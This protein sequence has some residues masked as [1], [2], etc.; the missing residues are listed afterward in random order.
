MVRSQKGFTAS[1]SAT[2][3]STMVMVPPD[4]WQQR[5]SKTADKS[6]SRTPRQCSGARLRY[7]GVGSDPCSLLYSWTAWLHKSCSPRWPG[8][9]SLFPTATTVLHS[10]D[11]VAARRWYQ[12]G[13]LRR[14]LYSDRTAAV[15]LFSSS[16]IRQGS[17]MVALQGSK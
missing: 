1:Q 13:R 5:C 10:S 11:L 3:P 6:A 14:D 8:Q 2:P 4:P 7:R 12:G 17:T 15:L 9:A 16:P